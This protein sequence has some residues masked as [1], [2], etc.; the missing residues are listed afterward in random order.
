MRIGIHAGH[1]GADLLHPLQ[2]FSAQAFEY[3][4]SR[5]W[6]NKPNRT[7][8]QIRIGGFDS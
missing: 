1:A 6:S 7:V 2:K 4:L 3:F 8:K 5:S